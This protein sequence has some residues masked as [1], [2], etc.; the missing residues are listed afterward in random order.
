MKLSPTFVPL[1]HLTL[2]CVLPEK[3][4]WRF[5]VNLFFITFASRVREYLESYY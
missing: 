3:R 5:N 2:E 1:L 4:H